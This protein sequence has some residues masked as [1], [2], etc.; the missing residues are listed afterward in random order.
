MAKSAG[1]LLVSRIRVDQVV[2]D[3]SGYARDDNKKGICMGHQWDNDGNV[4]GD[5]HHCHTLST[6]HKRLA[7]SEPKASSDCNEYVGCCIL[8]RNDCIAFTL[9]LRLA[10]GFSY[11]TR[12]S[13][14]CAVA[15][16]P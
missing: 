11:R 6:M 16:H 4:L 14:S 2:H 3:T 13:P 12:G 7:G 8:N 1:T 15:L 9:L 10:P 5:E